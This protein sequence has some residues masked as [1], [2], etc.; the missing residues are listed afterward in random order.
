[1]TYASFTL[2]EWLAVLQ[3]ELLLFAA[4]FFVIGAADELAVDI[5]WLWLRLTGRGKAQRC[6]TGN[7]ADQAL[8]GMAAV[9]IPAWQEAAVIGTTISHALSV[10]PQSKLRIY[11]GCYRND[12]A[13]IAAVI[14]AAGGDQR[15]RLVIHDVA[16]P[17]T[18][19]DCLNRLYAALSEDER[20]SGNNSHMVLLHDAEDMVDPA[21]L[22][23]LDRAIQ[24]AELAQLPVLPMPQPRSRWIGSHYCEEF[25]E[26]HGK[27]MVLR[28]AMGT[29]LPSAGVGCAISRGALFLL[30]AERGENAPFAADCLTEDYE[31]GLSI[32]EMGGR[33]RFVRARHADG[34]LVATRACFPH[35]LRAAVRQ[36]TRWVL[37]IAF[38]GWDRMGWN[39][40]LAERWMRLRDR[41]GPFTALV[42]AAAYAL[43]VLAGFASLLSLLGL[44]APF[45]ISPLL[46]AL[47]VI[48]FASFL[49]RAA[50]RF[51]FTA[52]EYGAM[53]G[54][55]SILRI[56]VTN[57][58]AIMAGRRALVSYLASLAGKMPA[59]DKTAHDAHPAS[60]NPREALT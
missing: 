36:K 1:M 31:L 54:L 8:S 26:A 2:A 38:Q 60:P 39:G 23:L 43:L 59:W 33:T 9:F 10:W 18:K 15:L 58:I 42:L 34:Q 32:A 17:S 7:G 49:W 13:T 41:R 21:G 27:A 20:R 29:G 47:L 3:H 40:S 19:A 16:G 51:A 11:V 45:E 12:V 37:G 22:A 48:N 28:D 24:Q 5:G 25:A 55:R 53:E 56:P 35:E 46:R 6:G 4:I 50:F 14:E 52:H 44:G 30:A 57:V